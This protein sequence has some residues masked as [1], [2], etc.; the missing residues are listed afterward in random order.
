MTHLTSNPLASSAIEMVRDQVALRAGGIARGRGAQQMRLQ[1][2]DEVGRQLDLT[3]GQ[4]RSWRPRYPR[5]GRRP[6]SAP[7][8]RADDLAPGRFRSKLLASSA[9]EIPPH[10]I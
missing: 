3:D 6:R 2:V 8:R 4:P 7:P 9:I 5:S 10:G 1:Y